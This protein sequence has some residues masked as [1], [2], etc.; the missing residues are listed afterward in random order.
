MNWEA[1][2]VL[3]EVIGAL[4]VIITRFYLA[5]QIRQNTNQLQGDAIATINEAEVTLLRD[6]RDDLDLISDYVNVSSDW[7][8][9]TPQQQARAHAHFV[10]WFRNR[11]TAY[12]LWQS[13]AL[14]E[15]I[16]ETREKFAV[17]IISASGSRKWWDRHHPMFEPKFVTRI[18][19]RA[20]KQSFSS[21]LE[22]DS[23]FAPEH[24]R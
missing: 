6:F 22:G 5:Y 12:N 16:Y 7:D 13:K 3:A 19:E 24:W 2:G 9:G 17:S 18:T 10:A 1:I 11:E 8:S 21:P 20:G 15:A 4:G 14:P 23:C